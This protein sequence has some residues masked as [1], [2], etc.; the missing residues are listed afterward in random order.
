MALSVFQRTIVT[1]TGAVIGGASVEVREGDSAG[2][3][4]TLYADRDGTTTLS[5]P[6]TADAEGLIRFYAPGGRYYILASGGGASIAWEDVP[7]GTAQYHDVQDSGEA[8]VLGSGAPGIVE[9]ARAGAILGWDEAAGAWRR[10]ARHPNRFTGPGP[11][12]LIGGDMEAGYFGQVPASELLTGDEL[13]AAIWGDLTSAPGSTT[14]TGTSYA[15]GGESN[16]TAG[17]L[18]FAHRGR[19]LF[20]AKRPFLNNISWDD[21]NAAG[22]VFGGVTVTADISKWEPNYT[23]GTQVPYI[24]RLLTGGNGDPTIGSPS[25]DRGKAGVQIGGGS[26]W[27][28][29][30]YRIHEQVPTDEESYSG[31]R[32]IGNNWANLTPTEFGNNSNDDGRRIRVQET[33]GDDATERV[34]RG[35]TGTVSFISSYSQSYAASDYGWRPVLELNTR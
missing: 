6:A 27:N 26:E 2:P 22:V 16:S 3:L 9:P 30:I 19:I 8:G 33:A 15:T 7:L 35:S 1:E 29:L 23:A 20:V 11:Q 12:A 4:A 14:F 28:D 10:Q 18:K 24:V 5:N 25:N 13:I 17:W 31:G 21:L 32:Q 34:H